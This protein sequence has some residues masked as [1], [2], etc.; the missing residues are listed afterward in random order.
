M[1]Q[2][3]LK[4]ELS[5]VKKISSGKVRE[6]YD[7]G[8]SLVF[9]SSDRLSAFD[10][11]MDQGIPYKGTV[12]NKISGFW[13]EMI[14]DII[15]THFISYETSDYP[16]EFH[17]YSEV[18]TG[19]SMLVKKGK[20][21][22]VECIVRG[23][24]SGSGWNDYKES[25]GISGI[26]LK[27]GLRESDKLDEPVFTPSTKAGIGSH[28]ENISFNKACEIAGKDIMGKIREAAIEIY[29]RCSSYAAKKGIIIAD[30]KMEFALDRDGNLMIADE[31][32][33]PDSSRFWDAGS[34]EPGKAQNS[35]DKQFVRD[36]LLSI[37]FNK[38]PPPPVLPDEII[39]KTAAK[40]LEAYSIL[41]GSELF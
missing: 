31:L 6:I 3:L 7:A 28:D 25:G 13:F 11:I 16:V 4:P 33:T 5:G 32:L 40:Y 1:T 23:Y 39:K 34:Y 19:R 35:Y 10:V 15:P 30:T 17:K 27:P 29:L 14:K 20:I 26:S 9:V 12:L 18:L 8:D 37:G 36:Y 38:Q 2:I 24:I 21:V 22:P 41:T